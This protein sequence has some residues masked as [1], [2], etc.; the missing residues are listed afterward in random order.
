MK[1]LFLMLNLFFS[2]LIF[3][4]IDLNAGMGLNFFSAPD[5]RDYIN[6]NFSTAED[7]SSFNTSAD[8]FC[9]IGYNITQDYQISFEY[10]FNIYSYNSSFNGGVYDFSLNHHKPSI[11]GYY[12]KSGIG[13]RFKFGGGVGLRIAQVDEELYGSTESYSTNGF[14]LLLKAQGD[15]KLGGDFYALIAGE[16]RYDM[17]GELETLTNS[18]INLNSFS[19]ALKLGIAYYL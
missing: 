15:T 2:S 5:L 12:V 17:P 18:K 14:G 1:K 8:F 7:M 11:I 3:A 19:L 9:E 10:N 13:Y 16:V 4:Q 6:S